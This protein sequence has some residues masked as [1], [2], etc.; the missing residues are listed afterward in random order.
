M[1]HKPHGVDGIMWDGKGIHIQIADLK[2]VPGFHQ[3]K[4]KIGVMDAADFLCGMPIAIHG[5]TELGGE[6]LQPADVVGMFV[7]N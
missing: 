1:Q 6:H 7:G 4:V 5:D 2:G 3:S